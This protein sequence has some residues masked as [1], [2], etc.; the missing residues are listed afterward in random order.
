MG[1][2]G[3]K[4]Q[5]TGQNSVRKGRK[6]GVVQYFVKSVQSKLAL[7]MHSPGNDGVGHTLQVAGQAAL[8][9][10]PS[11]GLVHWPFNAAQSTVGSSCLGLGSHKS[12]EKK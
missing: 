11:L 9:D 3:H 8:T 6:L 7:S 10:V 5:V 12:V 1:V 2:A 4:L